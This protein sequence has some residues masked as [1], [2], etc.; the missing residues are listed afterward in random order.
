MG[1]YLG[2]YMGEYLGQFMGEY[3]G[4]CQHFC[5]LGRLRPSWEHLG[6]V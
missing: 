5:V 2:E 1:E 3:L 4:E 6:T